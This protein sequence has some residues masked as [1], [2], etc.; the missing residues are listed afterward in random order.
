MPSAVSPFH[1]LN[2]HIGG[3]TENSGEGFDRRLFVKNHALGD[4]VFEAI[5]FNLSPH[6][7]IG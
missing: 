3:K 6:P 7:E 1:R 2:S 5:A 4:L